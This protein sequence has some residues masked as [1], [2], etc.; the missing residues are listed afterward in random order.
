M[1]LTFDYITIP[2]KSQEVTQ[3]QNAEQVRY[4][5]NQQEV[6][7]QV[8]QNVKQQ[9]EQTIRRNKAENEPNRYDKEEKRRQGRQKGSSGHGK[10]QEEADEQKPLIGESKFDIRV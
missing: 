8:Q 2:P 6:A 3:V 9:S 1:S 10:K 4:D 5:H 7:A